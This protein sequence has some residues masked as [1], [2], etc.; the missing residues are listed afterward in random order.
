MRGD[1]ASWN[2]A[3]KKRF[4]A[5]CRCLLHCL[6]HY[7]E[8]SSKQCKKPQK[9]T[10]HCFFYRNVVGVLLA[11]SLLLS[12]NAPKWE[13]TQ[14]MPGHGPLKKG[15]LGLVPVACVNN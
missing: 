15:G 12:N 14:I 10:A 2:E 7:L 3:K 8:G 1:G 4:V 9:C 11:S 5:C 6:S 13:F